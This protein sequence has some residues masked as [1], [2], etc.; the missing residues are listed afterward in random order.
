MLRMLGMRRELEDARAA[1]HRA[2]ERSLLLRGIPGFEAEGSA[3]A[4]HLDSAREHLK[5]GW[6]AAETGDRAALRLAVEV[7]ADLTAEAE[8]AHDKIETARRLNDRFDTW[9]AEGA[10]G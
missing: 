2:M 4:T 10:P 1:Y 8:T 7:A 3:S 6:L 5:A 9:L